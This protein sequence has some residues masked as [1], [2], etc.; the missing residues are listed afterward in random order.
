MTTKELII[1]LQSI[2]NELK[3]R[4]IS[5]CIGYKDNIPEYAEIHSVST[6]QNDWFGFEPS[7][8]DDFTTIRIDGLIGNRKP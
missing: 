6:H 2:P 4:N 7:W 3:N 1:A 8:D 5:V